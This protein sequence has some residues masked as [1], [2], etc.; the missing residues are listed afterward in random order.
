[1]L[2]F[3]VK[4]HRKPKEVQLM[5]PSQ[6][7][8]YFDALM[9]ALHDAF[10]VGVSDDLVAALPDGFKKMTLSDRQ[11]LYDAF[12][13]TR[14][15]AGI[16]SSMEFVNLGNVHA[17]ALAIHLLVAQRSEDTETKLTDAM[18]YDALQVLGLAF[19]AAS[20]GDFQIVIQ[21]HQLT[22]GFLPPRATVKA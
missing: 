20:Q 17:I 5:N 18:Y 14:N 6:H 1:M 15:I 12:V 13:R 3:A 21:H 7:S 11:R 10:G 9:L 8:P 22:N 2:R 16:P 19:E 4:I